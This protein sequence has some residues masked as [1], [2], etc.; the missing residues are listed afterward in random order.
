[1][2]HLLSNLKRSIFFIF[3]SVF[4][5]ACSS[6]NSNN[7]PDIQEQDIEDKI[8]AELSSIE[9][10]FQIEID[11]Q[12]AR[13]ERY[14]EITTQALAEI[15][16][17]QAA[18]P[19]NCEFN[20]EAILSLYDDPTCQNHVQSVMQLDRAIR[21]KTFADDS[22]GKHHEFIRSLETLKNNIISE[23]LSYHPNPNDES[24]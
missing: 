16:S 23:V 24:L 11:T 6:E 18:I 5:I 2:N 12:N 14:D 17:L 1:M 20:R 8:R 13:I 4:I 22:I 3:L 9:T 7:S 19:D 10:R 21:L 15:A